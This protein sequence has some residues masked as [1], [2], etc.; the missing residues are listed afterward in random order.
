MK[1]AMRGDPTVPRPI[2]GGAKMKT[3]QRLTPLA[4]NLSRFGAEE[5]GGALI[6]FSLGVI[7]LMLMMAVAV[8]YGRLTRARSALDYAADNAALTAARVGSQQLA[9]NNAHWNDAGVAAGT[10][11]FQAMSSGVSG[12]SAAPTPNVVLSSSGASVS[13]TV[14]YSAQ[15]QARLVTIGGLQAPTLANSVTA[16]TA[17]GAG[18]SDLPYVNVDLVLDVSPSMAIGA[19]AT[20]IANMKIATAGQ[21]EGAC[22]FACH[23]NDDGSAKDNYT[24]IRNWS[25]AHPASPIQLRF[26]VMKTAA[27][28]L[29]SYVQTQQG[30][31]AHATMGL[32]TMSYTLKNVLD[33]S[34]NASLITLN[35]VTASTTSDFTS[36]N[37]AIGNVDFDKL[38]T[39]ITGIS[40]SN[41]SI[42]LVSAP[43]S[44]GVYYPGVTN[45]ISSGGY[46]LADHYARDISTHDMPDRIGVSDFAT[47]LAQLA[48]TEGTSGDGNSSGSPK[49]VV[50]LITD[51]LFDVGVSYNSSST[52]PTNHYP[53]VA[54]FSPN[55]S[56]VLGQNS[57]GKFTSP[58]DPS[59]CTQLKNNGVTVGVLYVTYIPQ[60][61][62][63]NWEAIIHYNAPSSNLIDNMKSCAT[64]DKLFYNANSTSDLQS[65]IAT[66]LQNIFKAVLQSQAPHLTQ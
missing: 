28:A 11:M 16:S 14:S 15:T 49:K 22:A 6:L 21:K 54:N 66:G 36:Y 4:G 23:D 5:E 38:S 40:N 39:Y 62:E 2:H 37:T 64:S 45:A 63:G 30:L 29:A 51:G 8:D 25:T 27:Q 35:S 19:N 44:G 41:M 59:L 60:P 7:P 26:D 24:V 43:T 33:T 42:T 65:D 50:I 55:A 12:L 52:S 48:N 13:A 61:G 32:Y 58:I 57:W 17:P 1:R 53:N 56:E 20:D 3:S 47:T 34:K 46:S 10:T 9:A 31:T 18:V